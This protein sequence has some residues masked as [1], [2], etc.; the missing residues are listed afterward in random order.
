LLR[1]DS[2]KVGISL[3][4]FSLAV[5]VEAADRQGLLRDISEAF[6]KDRMNVTGVKTQSVRDSGGSTAFMTFTVEVAD[7]ARLAQVLRM[8]GQVSGV[9]A[10]RRK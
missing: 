5:V 3:S 2:D 9:R 10:V 8:V 7:A 4:N 6:S 1:S